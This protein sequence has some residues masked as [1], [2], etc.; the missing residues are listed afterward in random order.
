MHVKKKYMSTYKKMHV[1][2]HSKSNMHVKEKSHVNIRPLFLMFG[3]PLCR[4]KHLSL[5]FIDLFTTHVWCISEV[6]KT[7]Y[8]HNKSVGYCHTCAAF[9]LM[10]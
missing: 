8:K 1:N 7:P 4:P 3:D 9:S 5:G 2:M 10:T 6:R